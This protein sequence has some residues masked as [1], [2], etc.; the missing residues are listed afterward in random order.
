MINWK[1]LGF[2]IALTIVMFFMFMFNASSLA[3]LSFIIAPLVGTYIL[4]GELKMAA[5]YGAAISF[6]GSI[7]SIVLY[8]ALISY[9]SKTA[10]PLGLNVVTLIAVC[11]IYAVIGAVFGIAGAAIKNKLVEKQ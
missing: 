1:S 10:I 2:G 3:I 8:T 4:G 7:I 5:I 9:F 6:F 11:V